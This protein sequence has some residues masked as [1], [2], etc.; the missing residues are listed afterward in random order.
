MSKEGTIEFVA[1]SSESSKTPRPWKVTSS[2]LALSIILMISVLMSDVLPSVFPVN[3][4]IMVALS[5]GRFLCTEKVGCTLICP[6][7]ALCWLVFPP[8]LVLIAQYLLLSSRVL[9]SIV[10]M[11][12]FEAI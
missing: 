7:D 2:G 9:E 4:A 11:F 8:L 6:A 3:A 12:S 1:F 10:S 5:K